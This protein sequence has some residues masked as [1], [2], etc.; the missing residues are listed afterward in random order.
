MMYER[1]KQQCTDKG[2]KLKGLKGKSHSLGMKH[3]PFK[4]AIV[5]FG[6]NLNSIFFFKDSSLISKDN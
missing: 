1:A 3:A 6:G 2:S 5:L 4:L